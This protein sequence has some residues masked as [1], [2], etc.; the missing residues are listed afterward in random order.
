MTSTLSDLPDHRLEDE[1]ADSAIATSACQGNMS[2][3]S[4]TLQALILAAGVPRA[5]RHRQTR[6]FGPPCLSAPPHLDGTA[7]DA[8]TPA[9]DSSVSSVTACMIDGMKE[10]RFGGCL[11]PKATMPRGGWA[12]K[13]DP[14]PGGH[15]RSQGA[16]RMCVWC[17]SRHVVHVRAHTCSAGDPSACRTSHPGFGPRS[18]RRHAPW[19]VMHVCT[20]SGQGSHASGA[21]AQSPQTTP[22]WM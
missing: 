20:Q 14:C 10:H 4:L 16:C 6:H 7:G 13:S 9:R 12:V 8:P 11:K 2:A 19:P 5:Q 17:T 21:G 3:E 18:W 22:P 1:S 15:T